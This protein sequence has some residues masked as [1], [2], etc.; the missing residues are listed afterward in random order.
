MMNG[1]VIKFV[2]GWMGSFIGV[3]R[4]IKNMLIHFRCA[5]L[6]SYSASL[7]ARRLLGEGRGMYHFPS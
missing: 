1:S 5:V 3:I 7:L 4:E 2:D 6:L